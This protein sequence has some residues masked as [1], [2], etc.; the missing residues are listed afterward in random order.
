VA[1]AAL[2]AEL[3]RL[4]GGGAAQL[5]F[6]WAITSLCNLQASPRHMR[7]D[8]NNTHI[9]QHTRAHTYIHTQHT[10]TQSHSRDT[11]NSG[12][13]VIFAH[14]CILTAKRTTKELHRL[15]RK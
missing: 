11:H 13:E 15:V 9:Q 6:P 5:G 8:T 4:F 10:H 12:G 2:P 14:P 1:L 7:H 3:Q